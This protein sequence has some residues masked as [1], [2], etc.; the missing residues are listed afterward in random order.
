MSFSPPRLES[1]GVWDAPWGAWLGKCGLDISNRHGQF[2]RHVSEFPSSVP[3]N[4]ILRFSLLCVEIYPI[5]ILFYPFVFFYLAVTGYCYLIPNY[6]Y[7]HQLPLIPVSNIFSI[8]P[9]LTQITHTSIQS[10]NLSSEHTTHHKPPRRQHNNLIPHSLPQYP[11]L[12]HHDLLI[13]E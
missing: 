4:W 12:V 5:F 13:D 2:T 10:T 3:A 6:L 1:S 8:S 9:Y 11:I 7:S